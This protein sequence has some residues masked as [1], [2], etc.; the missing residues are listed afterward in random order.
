MTNDKLKNKATE[1]E[2]NNQLLKMEN[3]IMAERL[4]GL[5]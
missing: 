3:D 4:K 5:Y 2:H 1:L